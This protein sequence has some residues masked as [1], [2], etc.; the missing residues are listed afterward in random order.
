LPFDL[1]MDAQKAVT[2]NGG[3]KNAMH[4]DRQSE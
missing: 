2:Q 3:D 4:G 1:P